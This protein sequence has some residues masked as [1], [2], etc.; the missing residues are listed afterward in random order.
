MSPVVMLSGLVVMF[1]GLV[2]MFP[3]LVVMLP[4]NAVDTNATVSNDVQRIV[5][6]LFIS[7][8]LVKGVCLGVGRVR[9][10]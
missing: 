3:G 4:A 9:L 7:L 5:F 1:P 2:V 8:L 6:N 10:W